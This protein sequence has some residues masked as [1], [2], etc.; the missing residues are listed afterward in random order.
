[1]NKSFPSSIINKLLEEDTSITYVDNFKTTNFLN[2][3]SAKIALA[4]WNH[5]Q[6]WVVEIPQP[7]FTRSIVPQ[8]R[9]N[10]K[11]YYPKVMFSLK[12]QFYQLYNHSTDCFIVI[13]SCH[14]IVMETWISFAIHTSTSNI[15]GKGIMISHVDDS[16][17]HSGH[18]STY[19]KFIVRCRKD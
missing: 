3:L 16:S 8:F 14:K 4:M 15:E 18:K 2:L 6:C 10:S 9:D 5:T 7:W 13:E 19:K 1:M 12:M 17:A 11:E